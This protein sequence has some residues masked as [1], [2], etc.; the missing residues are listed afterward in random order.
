MG[1]G[2]GAGHLSARGC[3]GRADPRRQGPSGVTE[4]GWKAGRGCGY[5]GF[6]WGQFGMKVPKIGGSD[7]H[8]ATS[9]KKC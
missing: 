2:D 5:E 7:G 8:L 1:L 6:C 3:T 9:T 4:G